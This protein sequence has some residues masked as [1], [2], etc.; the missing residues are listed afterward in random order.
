LREEEEI[1]DQ[2][3]ISP[4][5]YISMIGSCDDYEKAL[6]V[7]NLLRKNLKKL[8]KQDDQHSEM[9]IISEYLA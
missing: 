5:E 8:R 4:Q 2:Q 1:D 6:K 3:T 9:N 7:R